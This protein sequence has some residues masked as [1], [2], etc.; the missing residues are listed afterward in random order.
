MEDPTYLYINKKV[1]MKKKENNCECQVC[2]KEFY[3][4]E[5]QIKS[6][7]YC[8]LICRD[9]ISYSYLIKDMKEIDSLLFIYEV[10]SD[11]S[12]FNKITGKSV[13]F[14]KDDKGYL[15]ARLHTSISNHKDGRK[16]YKL[17]R[18]IAM[19]YLDDYSNDLQVNH[20]NGIKTDNRVE[21]LEM[22]T[23]RDNMLHSWNVLNRELKLNRDEKGKFITNK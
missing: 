22:V 12:V 8:S 10:K 9:K 15:R 21:N 1:N 20:K 14:S 5:S 17:H 16:P 13:I 19:M 18:L 2:G 4:K 11:G 23:C 7:V 6:N 3:R